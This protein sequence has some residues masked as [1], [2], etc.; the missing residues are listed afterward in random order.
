MFFKK[1][2]FVV[3]LFGA[4]AAQAQVI[5]VSEEQEEE[6]KGSSILDDTTK[7]VYGPTTSKFTYQH[8][9]KYN[10]PKY[11]V[12]DTTITELHKYQYM[13][14]KER[15]YNNLGNIGTPANSIYPQLNDKIGLTSGFNIFDLYWD[16]PEE[17]KYYNTRS[18]YSRFKIIW[19]GQGRAIT[20]VVYARNIDARSGF[21]FNYRGLFIDKQIQRSGR[22]DRN[23]RGTYYNLHGHYATKD[24]KYRVLAN[25]IRNKHDVNEYGG[26]D[27]EPDAP[28]LAYFD[29]NRQLS[30]QSAENNEL[31]TNYHLYHQYKINNLLQV[32]HE[33]DRYK[34][35]ND[36]IDDLDADLAYFDII[37]V[38]ST[39]VKDRSKIVY[40]QNELGLKGDIGKTFYNL[41][42]KQRN[43]DFFYKYLNTDSIPSVDNEVSETY[44]GFNLRFGNDSTSYIEAF[45][46]YQL[47][48]NFK[49]GGQIQNNW[50][51]ARGETQQSAAPYVYQAYRGT[52][53]VWV[54]DFESQ[55]TTKIE[56]ELSLGLGSFVFKPG[57]SNTLISNYLYF[58]EVNPA[59]FD[60]QTVLP[61][62]ASS[63]INI[64]SPSFGFEYK[65][66][67]NFIFK[68][69]AIYNNVS[70]GSASA[71]NLPEIYARGRLAYGN[72]NFDGN[73][74]WQVGFDAYYRST[75]FA[76]GYDPAAM[77][78]YLQNDFEV[79]AFPLVDF[80]IDAKINRG[81][82]FLKLNN[83]Y[84]IFTDI[85][86]FAT[87][88]YPG[89]TTILDFGFDWAFYD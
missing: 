88:E 33:Y 23:T 35:Q 71:V 32:Y 20:D 34:Q 15:L 56:G 7:Q 39:E 76:N 6:R 58:E 27:T 26:I 50:L 69:K 37:E 68:A 1:I 66:W 4:T 31:R 80:F 44:G 57:V 14:K 70:G 21:G 86:Y 25:F 85:G 41:Y 82:F 11:W 10:N 16:G 8:N 62:Q 28:I 63:D 84:E 61:N 38:D 65:F 36:F 42:F 78:F 49:L 19:G 89:Q 60:G 52:H 53:D 73:L 30:L 79:E 83:V 54:N 67:R 5:D 45:G 74:E 59:D 75:Y 40:N 13:V 51:F 64:L 22:G 3:L 29:E 46:E 18:P 55:I 9:I 81:R 24:G 17:I 48:G 77:Q 2:F 43:V 72:I 87:P 12:I 47:G